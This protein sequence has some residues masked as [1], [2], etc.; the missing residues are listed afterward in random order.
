MIDTVGADVIDRVLGNLPIVDLFHFGQTHHRLLRLVRDEYQ[1]R[2]KKLEVEFVPAKKSKFGVRYDESTGKL[3]VN[4][5][6]ICSQFMNM[7][8]NLIQIMSINYRESELFGETI[9]PRIS[10]QFARNLVVIKMSNWPSGLSINTLAAQFPKVTTL[11][12]EDFMDFPGLDL[13]SET[14]PEVTHLKIANV[15]CDYDGNFEN[16][17]HLQI[18]FNVENMG[19]V[20]DFLLR[21]DQIQH[22]DVFEFPVD[23]DNVIPAPIDE[24][25]GSTQNFQSLR[26]LIFQTPEY[27]AFDP[28]YTKPY[29]MLIGRNDVDDILLHRNLVKLYVPHIKMNVDQAVTIMDLLQYLREFQFQVQDQQALNEILQGVHFPGW[30]SIPSKFFQ[31]NKIVLLKRTVK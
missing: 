1:R 27:E 9:N 19:T 14:F 31:M 10:K 16:L 18:E 30:R 12:I 11:E 6:K 4:G 22:L 23:D 13:L 5:W 2:F 3:Y 26:T 20:T 24:I 17:V 28:L 25:L 8:E 7:F 15:Q 21:H 29:T